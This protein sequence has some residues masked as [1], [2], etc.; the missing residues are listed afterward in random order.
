MPV[1]ATSAGADERLRASPNF[2]LTFTMDGRPYI[3]RDSQPYVQYWLMERYRILLGLFSGRGGAGVEEAV[4]GYFRLTET[5]P[6]PAA[7]KALA[8]A[9]RDMRGAGVLI[10]AR[11]DTSRYDSRIA[12]D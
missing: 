11:H 1:R 2:A 10:G 9:I 8:A 12:A 3:A 4:A 7:S 6:T 5:A